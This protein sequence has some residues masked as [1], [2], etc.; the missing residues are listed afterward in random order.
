VGNTVFASVIEPHG[1]YTPVSEL[2][3]N[4]NTNITGFQVVYDSKDYTAVRVEDKSGQMSLLIIA[5][6]GV[7]A[8]KRH[9]LKIDGKKLRWQG[10]YYFVASES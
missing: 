10:P 3:V 8:K 2:S 7:S 1:S 6:G 4:P 5:N 9:L